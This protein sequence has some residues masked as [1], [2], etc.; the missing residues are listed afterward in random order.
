MT[1]EETECKCCGLIYPR[2]LIFDGHCPYCINVNECTKCGK[3]FK[4]VTGD[5]SVLCEECEG[6][7]EECV[8]SYQQDKVK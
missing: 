4:T 7:Q 2:V 6:E 1:F 5:D 8:D 3:E